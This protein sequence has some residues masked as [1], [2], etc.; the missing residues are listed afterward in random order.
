MKH[1]LASLCLLGI[2]LH[3]AAQ[4]TA[5]ASVFQLKGNYLT[6]GFFDIHYAN[7]PVYLFR[8]EAIDCSW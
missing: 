4:C 8:P 3:T 2:F 5:P 7:G 1:C 6:G